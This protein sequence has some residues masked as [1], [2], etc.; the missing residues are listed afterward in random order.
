M[1]NLNLSARI[2]LRRE[3]L[4]LTLEQ[5]GDIVG[6]GKST[7]RKWE[8]GA[9]ANMRRDKISG[10]ARALRTSP[11][12]LMGWTDDP[13]DEAAD[14]DFQDP[15]TQKISDLSNDMTDEEKRQLLLAAR[16]IIEQRSE[17]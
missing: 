15:L 8:T 3:Q 1:N 10:L 17:K 6:V 2:R 9:I 4:G 5:V 13:S 12:F 14:P 11:A 7:V 16:L